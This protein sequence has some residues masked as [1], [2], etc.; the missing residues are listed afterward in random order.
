MEVADKQVPLWDSRETPGR[1]LGSV[2][3]TVEVPK[4]FDPHCIEPRLNVAETATRDN[5][6]GLHARHVLENFSAR[7]S[8]DALWNVETQAHVVVAPDTDSARLA[9]Q[10]DHLASPTRA[11]KGVTGI[12][13]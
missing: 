13:E 6:L 9:E 3:W 5:Q 12:P 11:A 1:L 2:R 10:G 8:A 7:L 4:V